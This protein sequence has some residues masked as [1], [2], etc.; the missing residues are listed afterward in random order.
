M[1]ALGLGVP[2]QPAAAY[3]AATSPPHSG[4]LLQLLLVA[5]SVQYLM[6]MSGTRHATH[7]HAPRVSDGLDR[8]ERLGGAQAPALICSLAQMHARWLCSSCTNCDASHPPG[9]WC[10]IVT[11]SLTSLGRHT[12]LLFLAGCLQHN[13]MQ[14]WCLLII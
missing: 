9:D 6:A 3:A 8:N 13:G 7:R 10:L 5:S 1:I 4:S 11:F 12:L 14:V 2:G